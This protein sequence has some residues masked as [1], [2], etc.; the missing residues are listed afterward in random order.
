[1]ASVA[2]RAALPERVF[3]VTFFAPG[4]RL[5]GGSR[6]L[7]GRVL[8]HSG[9]LQLASPRGREAEARDPVRSKKLVYLTRQTFMISALYSDFS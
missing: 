9:L 1:M 2:C 7:L 8:I 5:F 6:L 4:P 3:Q